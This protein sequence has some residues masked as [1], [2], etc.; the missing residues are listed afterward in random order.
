MSNPD[1]LSHSKKK[2]VNVAAWIATTPTSIQDAVS[3][4]SANNVNTWAVLEITQSLT[5]WPARQVR[6]G[7][8]GQ[9]R[10]RGDNGMEMKLQEPE[11][12]YIQN[13]GEGGEAN[14]INKLAEEPTN[15]ATNSLHTVLLEKLKV[16]QLTRKFP[17]FYKNRKFIAAFTTAHNLS[18]CWTRQIKSL[19]HPKLIL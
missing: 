15:Q 12:E 1:G 11:M 2:I 16:P 14:W 13:L 9:Q 8:V 6:S 5:E 7:Q 17:E 10:V 19:R 18:L 4:G 3:K